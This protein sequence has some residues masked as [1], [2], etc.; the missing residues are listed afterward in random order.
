VAHFPV[1]LALV[2]GT[3]ARVTAPLA[4]LTIA[5]AGVSVFWRA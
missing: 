1:T 2:A 4:R 5:F 3:F